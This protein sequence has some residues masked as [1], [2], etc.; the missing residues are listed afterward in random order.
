[1]SL[2]GRSGLDL[3]SWW[4][5][6]RK[7]AP[8]LLACLVGIFLAWL[9]LRVVFFDADKSGSLALYY[10]NGTVDSVVYGIATLGDLVWAPLIFWLYVFRKERYAWTSAV[11]LAV[12]AVGSM[13]AVFLL[14]AGFNLPRPFT[15]LPFQIKALGEVPP[16]T[17]PGFPSGHTTNAFTV[18]SVIWARYPGWRVPF[19]ALAVATGISMIVLGLHFPSD[20]IAGAFL[21]TLLGAFALSLG[22]LRGEL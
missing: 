14:K 15:V 1:M 8:I 6:L 13:V 21:G 22:R 10:A 2:F 20:V 11:I 9:I 5:G 16:P 18:A 17:N 4:L 12:A 19:L 7:S 3:R